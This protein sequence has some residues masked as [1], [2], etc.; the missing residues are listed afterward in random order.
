MDKL[1][2]YFENWSVTHFL[3]CEANCDWSDDREEYEDADMQLAWESW[4]ASRA[5]IKVEIN[6]ELKDDFYSYPLELFTDSL[7]EAGISYE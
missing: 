7:T 3:L 4:Q 6:P 5:A 2:K 1:R